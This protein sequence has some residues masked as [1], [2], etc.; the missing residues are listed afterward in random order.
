MALRRLPKTP[1]IVAI[2]AFSSAPAIAQDKTET[3]PSSPTG[4]VPSGSGGALVVPQTPPQ[5]GQ[6]A[7][8]AT[9]PRPLN[10]APPEYPPEAEK[11]GLE[12]TVTL[13]LDIDRT[14]KVTRA[15]V[16]EPAGHGFD[17]AAVNAAKKLEFEPARRADGTPF[18][19]RIRYRYSFNLQKKEP[20]PG[21]GPPP[22]AEVAEEREGLSGTVLASGGDAPLAGVSIN[23]KGVSTNLRATSTEK[24]A[25]SFENLPPGKYEVTIESAGFQPLTV[26]EEVVAGERTEVKYRLL[27]VGTGLEVTIRGARPPREVT[28]RTLQAREINRIPGTNGDA[29]RSIQSLP[30]VARP[31]AIAGILIVRGSSPQDTQTFVDGTQVP[32]IYHFG[33]L[34]S[35]V[36]TEMLEK[37]DFYPGNFSAQYGRVMGGIVDA[38]L[39]SPKDDGKYHGLAQV[40]FIDARL[41]A[42]GP[43][44]YLKGWNFMVGARRSHIDSWLGPL[45]ESAGA[46]VTQA[47]VYYDYQV[48]VETKP[49]PTSRFRAAFFGSDDALE[50]IVKEPA[51]NEPALSGNIGLNTEFQRIQLRY[52]NDFS[53]NDSLNALFA[54]GQDDANFGL[55]AFYFLLN[56]KSI[57]G[58]LEYTR[59]MSKGVRLN[60]GLDMVWSHYVANVRIPA[61]SP[62][63]Q[64]ANQPFSTRTARELTSEGNGYFP[65]MYAELEIA[66][67]ER[68]K[69]VPGIRADYANISGRLDVSPRVNGRYDILHGYPRTTVKGGVGI[70]HQPPQFQEAVE[71]SGTAGLR[72]NRAIQ[73]SI[74][75]EQDITRN[76]ELSVEGFY[77]QLDSLVRGG[78]G[79]SGTDILYSNKGEGFVVGGELLLKY[80]PDDRFFGWLAYTLSRSVRVDEPGAEE[81]LVPFD[82]PHILT[83]LGSY[84]LGHGWE[85]GARFRLVSG[86]LITPTVCNVTQIDCNPNRT[87]ALFHAASGAYT[88]IPFSGPATER[89]PL[90]HALDVR[91]DKRWKFKSWQL[92]MYL[93]IQNAYN[94]GNAEGVGYSYNYTQRQYV[95]GLTALPSFGIRAD[96]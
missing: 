3:P 26:E 39:R 54:L 94:N 69:I 23:L 57:S 29:L 71:P 31:P 49:S 84:Q 48:M 64:P 10:Y 50:I 89:L 13:E 38:G 35:V 74:G 63:G 67:S 87:N 88:P 22:A 62:P 30:G 24:G 45:L 80:K 32:L 56:I 77:K 25:F 82:Q 79:P 93:D 17:E 46:G 43:I 37:I 96:F 28:K 86:N 8:K 65:A 44:P 75:G 14:G 70:F 27:P 52:D 6:P 42:E 7:G 95:A 78:A 73:Y 53:E 5:G 34:S 55:G 40:D 41:M 85:I 18:A 58:R 66:P 60:T 9:L 91:V 36:P 1:L 47:P 4:S 76:L 59:R 2:L 51:P 83:V 11:Q 90:Y 81:R 12:G 15:A 16:L 21:E 68:A 33:G 20:A 61:P 72:T 92:S 19:A